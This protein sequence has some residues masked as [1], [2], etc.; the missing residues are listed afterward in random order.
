MWVISTLYADVGQLKRK[1]NSTHLAVKWYGSG[2]TPT[3][4]AKGIYYDVSHTRS[5]I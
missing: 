2:T 3:K 4:L 1:I 5:H